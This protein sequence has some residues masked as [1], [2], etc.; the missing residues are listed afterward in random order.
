[1]CTCMNM[2]IPTWKHVI[3]HGWQSEKVCES[4]FTSPSRSLVTHSGHHV[5]WQISSPNGLPYLLDLVVVF[6]VL[7]SSRSQYVAAHDLGL[8]ILLPL[9][10]THTVLDYKNWSPQPVYMA[11]GTKPRALNTPAKH[12]EPQA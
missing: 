5:W 7:E 1:M 3:M 4:W 12:P 9:S 11:L 2:Y 6:C 10:H 8:L